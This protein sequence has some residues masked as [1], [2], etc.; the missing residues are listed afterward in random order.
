MWLPLAFLGGTVDNES[1]VLAPISTTTAVIVHV[2]DIERTG[3]PFVPA[4]FDKN[5]A[6]R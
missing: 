3:N 6:R 2:N 1:D 4:A 5:V